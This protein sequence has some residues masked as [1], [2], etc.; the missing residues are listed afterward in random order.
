MTD[1]HIQ[2]V[3][4]GGVMLAESPTMRSNAQSLIDSTGLK[5]EDFGD[6]KARL[7]WGIMTK[8]AAARRPVSPATIY[9]YGRSTKSFTERDQ[10]WLQE[11]ENMGVALDRATFDDLAAGMLQ[12]CRIAQ[13]ATVLETNLNLLRTD[14]PNV[15][16]IRLTLEAA[17]RETTVALVDKSSTGEQDLI[18]LAAKWER[19]ELGEEKAD[20]IPTGIQAL[21][22][23]I[24]G[25]YANL[26][27]I[28]G[29][30]SEGKSAFVATVIEL[31]LYAGE[32]V[33]VFGLEDG[34]QWIQ[35]RHVAKRMGINAREVGRKKRGDIIVNGVGGNQLWANATEELAPLMRNLFTNPEAG[36]RPDVLLRIAEKWRLKGCR[37]FFVDHGGELDHSNR[38]IDEHRLRIAASYRALRN[39][40]FNNGVAVVAVAHTRRKDDRDVEPRPPRADEVRDCS[41]IENMARMMIGVWSVP[42]E[43]YVRLT[44]AKVTEGAR[45]KT[46]K[47]AKVAGGVLLDPDNCEVIDLN[48][49]KMRIAKEK[50]EKKEAE[51]KEA[52]ARR[53]AEKAAAKEKA[54]PKQPGLDLND[55]RR[56][57]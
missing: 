7:V 48:V 17:L 45:Y 2:H 6:A 40:A 31:L 41:D 33:G 21:D 25:F 11:M 44:S 10:I 30:P 38:N 12:Q 37:I 43:D 57:S 35:R 27:M 34:T 53:A 42:G 32:K 29:A 9:A 24:G 5:R 55:E 50:K 3:I 22:E 36:L 51:R 13:L 39:W 28:I 19:V 47:V 8:L 54:K 16:A 26:N 18:D 56:A 52:V 15:E 23:L 1:V 46:V 49:E 20:V 14:R 4:C